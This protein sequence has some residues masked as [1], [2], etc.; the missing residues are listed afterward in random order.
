V[1]SAFDIARCLAL[2]AD[3]CNS[4]RGFMFALGCIQSRSCHTDHCPTGVAT[5]D[6]V[7]QR[8]IVVTDK[9]ERVYYF[10][11][12]TL[13]ALADLVG[14]AGLQNP[15]EITPHHLMVRNADGQARTLASSIDTLATSQLLRAPAGPQTLPSPFAEFWH[16]SQAA[17]WGVPS[18]VAPLPA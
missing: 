4:A 11:A 18:G 17:H 10:H 5:Q 12:N 2:G 3:W 7:R 6:P 13:H 1:I 16:A 9:A 14:A 8:A 15:G